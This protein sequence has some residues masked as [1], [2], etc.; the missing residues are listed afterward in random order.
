MIP[1]PQF[2][3]WISWEIV[4]GEGVLLLSEQGHFLLRGGVY[5]RLAPLLNGR[6]TV[7][8]II[9]CLQGQFSAVE[10]FSAL[11]GL[12]SKGY[13]VDEPL[14]LPSEQAA[15]WDLL[16]GGANNAARHLQEATVSV[17]SFGAID[18]AP[19]QSMLASLGVQVS[20]DGQYSVVLADD[21]LHED[22]AAFNQDALASDRPWLLVKPVGTELWLGPLFLPE[23]TACWACLAHRLRGARKVEHYLQERLG[24]SASIPRPVAVLPSTLP[25]ALS[26]AA[27]ETAKWI[28]RGRNEDVEGR[29]VS[30]NALTLAKRSHILARRPQCSHCGDPAAFASGQAVPI[31]LQ[32]CKKAFMT[33]GGHRILSPEET[34]KKLAHHISPITGI[35]HTLQPTT[36][37]M[38]ENGLVL[39][40]HQRIIPG[41]WTFLT[42]PCAML[43]LVREG[44]PRKLKPAPFAKL[45][46]VIQASSKEMKLAFGPNSKISA[47]WLFI[48]TPVCSSARC[49][50][51]I[52]KPGT[53]W[54]HRQ[55]GYRSHLTTLKR[56]SGVLCGR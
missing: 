47:A 21:Y 18:P 33:D 54:A 27:T 9:L 48:P 41:T 30:V 26:I 24:A 20:N 13:I 39:S 38:G 23:R 40:T 44:V 3:P 4:P 14:S 45:S 2:K 29:V 1:R 34:L 19:F 28:V 6:N 35:V 56:S 55:A 22:L 49:N 31:V 7:D 42:Q 37:W 17:V 11:M 50:L 51:R 15:F 8:E 12:R 52:A 53:Q 5:T 46:N 25:T 16:D 43:Q 10:V 36:E 32:S